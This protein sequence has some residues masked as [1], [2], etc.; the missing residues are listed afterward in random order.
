MNYLVS[1]Q[2]AIDFIEEN[3]EE[4]IELEEVAKIASMSLP[5]LYRM[6]YS[7]T[8]HPVKDYM[9]RRRIS[10]A[11]DHL[12][13]SNRTIIDIAIHIGF[14]SQASFTKTFK[15]IVGITPKVYKES[16]MFFCFDRIDLYE[17]INYLESRELFDRYP[18]I[19]VIQVKDMAVLSY[20]HRSDRLEGIEKDALTA[21]QKLVQAS[22]IKQKRMRIFGRNIEYDEALDTIHQPCRYEIMVSI[23]DPLV[24]SIAGMSFKTIQGGM[25]AVGVTTSTND[26]SILSLWNQMYSEWLPKSSFNEG[27]HTY[28]EEYMTFNEKLVRMKLYLPIERQLK[29]EMI[30]V[31]KTDS[32]C[33]GYCRIYGQGCQ[34]KADKT[35]F[36][37]LKSNPPIDYSSAKLYFSYNYDSENDLEHWSEYGITNYLSHEKINTSGINQ[38]VLG[39]GLFAVM[40]TRAYGTLA[41]ILEIVHRWIVSGGTYILDDSRQ[42]FAQ[43]QPSD[44]SPSNDNMCVRSYIPIIERS[45]IYG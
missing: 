29:P 15:K 19:K 37:W 28:L 11:S 21:V 22:D 42:W 3:I 39:G 23:E 27:T 5:H 8:G 43:Y 32:F 9:R 14:E 40:E 25:Y 34:E 26:S 24:H 4:K 16:D 12:K 20:I 35:L 41:G 44:A 36:E 31:E 13:Y 17:K 38:K 30:S 45:K 6:F 33:A 1:V 18:D 10:I 7:L 2:A